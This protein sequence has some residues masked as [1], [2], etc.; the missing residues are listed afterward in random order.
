[1]F[2]W[3][4]EFRRMAN[5]GDNI[6]NLTI[7]TTSMSPQCCTLTLQGRLNAVSAPALKANLRQLIQTGNTQF[8]MDLTGV[9]FIDSSGL[10]ALISGLKLAR[11]AFGFLKLAGLDEQVG[12]VF[13]LTM[14]D[15]VFEV[16]PDAESALQS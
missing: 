13:R 9:T 14:L 12:S 1:M 2:R 15:R 5:F 6:M 11:E 7:T 10:A 16:Y 8:I 3:C 4:A